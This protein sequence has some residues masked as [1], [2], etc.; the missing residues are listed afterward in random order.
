MFLGIPF[1]YRRVSLSWC[2]KQCIN[3]LV[4]YMHSDPSFCSEDL[5]RE[6]SNM[7]DAVLLSSVMDS[8]HSFS[9][10]FFY[11]GPQI[12]S[13]H[14]IFGF[15]SFCNCSLYFIQNQIL[16]CYGTTIWKIKNILFS[17]LLMKSPPFPFLECTI[18]N[19]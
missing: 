17:P 5:V 15:C 7:G 9:Y 1:R 13:P 8:Y 18:L 2:V 16:C 6:N 3:E 12:L 10:Q 14:V 4:L 11:L 19:R